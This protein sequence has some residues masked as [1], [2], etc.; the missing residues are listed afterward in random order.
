MLKQGV[1]FNEML[2]HLPTG[3]TTFIPKGVYPFK[4]LA[5]ADHHREDCLID[6]M[7]QTA[8]IKL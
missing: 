3:H 5:E 6:G 8:R 1:L 4:T 7:A 2:Q